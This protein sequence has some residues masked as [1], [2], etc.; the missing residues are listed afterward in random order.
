MSYAGRRRMEPE[1]HWSF[2][3]NLRKLGLAGPRRA[4]SRKI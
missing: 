4:N 3:T 2:W 1:G